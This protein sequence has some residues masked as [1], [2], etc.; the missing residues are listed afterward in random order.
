MESLRLL[1]AAGADAD[2]NDIAGFT[3]LHLTAG[4]GSPGVAAALLKHGKPQL[5]TL[6]QKNMYGETALALAHRMKFSA[7]EDLIAAEAKRV[8]VEG[9]AN[10]AGTAV[11]HDDS[12]AAVDVCV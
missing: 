11:V 7:V 3:P 5:R 8:A 6:T 12:D 2:Q 9:G 1:L 4:Y 10:T